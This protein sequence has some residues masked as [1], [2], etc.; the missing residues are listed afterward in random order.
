MNSREPFE[1]KPLQDERK[2]TLKMNSGLLDV[3]IGT[4]CAHMQLDLLSDPAFSK[5]GL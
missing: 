1:N 5:E 3:L 4:S 2:V